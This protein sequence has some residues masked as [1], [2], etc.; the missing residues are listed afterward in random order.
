M[1]RPRDYDDEM[2]SE[3][4]FSV[5]EHDVFPEEFAPFL[6]LSP[7]LLDVFQGAHGDLLTARYWQT[8]QARIHRGEVIELLP[9]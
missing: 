3:P 7:Q 1:P 4:W 5:G 9:Y 2:A 6:G 8:M